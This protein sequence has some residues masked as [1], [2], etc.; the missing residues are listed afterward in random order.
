MKSKFRIFSAFAAFACVLASGFAWGAAKGPIVNEKTEISYPDLKSAFA[1]VKPGE[2]LVLLANFSSADLVVTNDISIFLNSHRI[3]NASFV[4]TNGASFVVQDGNTTTNFSITGQFLVNG[5]SLKLEGGNYWSKDNLP[6]IKTSNGEMYS[7]SVIVT[8]AKLMPSVSGVETAVLLE[9]RTHFRMDGNAKITHNSASLAQEMFQRGIFISTNGV[10]VALEVDSAAIEVSDTAIHNFSQSCITLNAATVNTTVGTAIESLSGCT[11][12]LTNGTALTAGYAGIRTYCAKV[13]IANSTV[14]G[15]VYAAVLLTNG[16]EGACSFDCSGTKTVLSGGTE[17]FGQGIMAPSD[18][19]GGWSNAIHLCGGAYS[20]HPRSEFERIVTNNWV[21][22]NKYEVTW[23]SDTKFTVGSKAAILYN[24]DFDSQP[25]L[26]KNYD[27]SSGEVVLETPEKLGVVNTNGVFDGWYLTEGAANSGVGRVTSVTK[28]TTVFA[29]WLVKIDVTYCFNFEGAEPSSSNVVYGL[30]GG[31]QDISNVTPEFLG[32]TNNAALFVGWYDNQTGDGSAVTGVSQTTNLWAK[33]D[34]CQMMFHRNRNKDDEEANVIGL[35]PL[36]TNGVVDLAASGVDNKM[37]KWTNDDKPV[38]VGWSEDPDGFGRIVA[39]VPVPPTTTNLYA[40]WS[41]KDKVAYVDGKSYN[42]LADAILDASSNSVIMLLADIVN[43]PELDLAGKSV[44]IDF[45]GKCIGSPSAEVVINVSGEGES[46]FFD[47]MGTNGT[48]YGT[49]NIRSHARVRI[50]GGT[51]ISQTSAVIVADGTD[52]ELTAFGATFKGNAAAVTVVLLGADDLSGYTLFSNSVIRSV[53]DEVAV[54]CGITLM[55]GELWLDETS[56]SAQRRGIDIISEDEEEGK[57]FTNICTIVNGS[58]ISAY[59]GVQSEFADIKVSDSS[60]TAKSVGNMKEPYAIYLKSGGATVPCLLMEGTNMVIGGEVVYGKDVLGGLFYRDT[61]WTNSNVITITGGT[62]AYQDDDVIVTNIANGGWVNTNKCIL[63]WID[64][65]T[66]K[67]T[68]RAFTF[69]MRYEDWP[70]VVTNMFSDVAW[71][72]EVAVTGE[73]NHVGYVYVTATNNITPYS[74]LGRMAPT[75]TNFLGWS[76]DESSKV[77]V[78]KVVYDQPLTLY[79]VWTNAWSITYKPNFSKEMIE[80]GVKELTNNNNPTNYS[81]NTVIKKF[82]EATASADGGRYTTVGWKLEG[83]GD[84][85]VVSISNATLWAS[86]GV[87]VVKNPGDITLV[88]QWDVGNW[89]EDPSDWITLATGVI[90]PDMETEAYW[91]GE[92]EEGR[93][94]WPTIPE[95]MEKV[96]YYE[97]DVDAKLP[98]A[99][100]VKWTDKNGRQHVFSYWTVWYEDIE[101]ECIVTEGVYKAAIAIAEIERIVAKADEKGWIWDE[102]LHAVW[103]Q[104]GGDED[105]KPTFDD[106]YNDVRDKVMTGGDTYV[107]FIIREQ[108]DEGGDVGSVI[109]KIVVK[110]G[111]PKSDGFI[112]ASIKVTLNG[113]GSRSF[114]VKKDEGE[115]HGR[116]VSLRLTREGEG[117]DDLHDFDLTLDSKTISGLYNGYKVVGG[118]NLFKGSESDR[119][120]AESAISPFL[121]RWMFIF[122]TTEA[123]TMATDKRGEAIDEVKVEDGEAHAWGYSYVGMEIRDKGKVRLTGKLANGLEVSATATAIIGDKMMCVPAT[124]AVYSGKR[125]GGF[126]FT[127]YFRNGDSTN[128]IFAASLSTNA[129]CEAAVDA[130]SVSLWDSTMSKKMPFSAKVVYTNWQRVADIEMP[131][132]MLFCVDPKIEDLKGLLWNFD[133]IGEPVG[134]YD[135]AEAW[136]PLDPLQYQFGYSQYIDAIPANDGTYKLKVRGKTPKMKLV[137][138]DYIVPSRKGDNYAGV[139]L[140]YDNKR[141]TFSGS[142]KVYTLKMDDETFE[143]HLK[144]TKV[145]V[146]GA[147]ADGRGWGFGHHKKAGSQPITLEDAAFSNRTSIVDGAM[148]DVGDGDEGEEIE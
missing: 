79:A 136:L 2:R 124:C 120:K 39:T 86:N 128:D 50:D 71:T 40:M 44:Q 25:P 78:E 57:T 94:V 9:G 85:Y 26:E 49:I 138:D 143:Y 90:D 28:P 67:V 61:A 6:V 29:R 106:M 127:A 121:G 75:N 62:Y 148:I 109:G 140:K 95:E 92:D 82:Y 84:D 119:A 60:I 74:L 131:N 43:E 98:T 19:W 112:G 37:F 48:V 15:G 97:G 107:G 13:A 87:A 118:V 104:G 147:M 122:A 100:D 65:T 111:T 36:M 42:S 110:L 108:Q 141:G 56:I 54:E 134:T 135:E 88:A 145:S 51:Y 31:V 52:Y 66:F 130:D 30:T 123:E 115:Y 81:E 4:V 139:K 47:S 35:L 70:D 33:W 69:K 125:G 116:M 27:I 64:L 72:N 59:H 146:S 11:C 137:D 24:F 91:N 77:T 80:R 96:E 55:G 68:D 126:G 8:N 83:G 102:A 23:G 16:V 105:W 18:E 58:S 114:S 113:K 22:V 20:R 14:V 133:R 7:N 63:E 46:L 76:L 129:V 10:D 101:N 34:N 89:E 93:I 144:K 117:E 73:T 103:D 41:A 1:N 53:S 38:F 99:G 21:D 3:S 142:F 5:G 45:N 32:A 132:E 12:V 17:L